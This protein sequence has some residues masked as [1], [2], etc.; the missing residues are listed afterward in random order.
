VV[1]A[2]HHLHR[3]LAIRFDNISPESVCAYFHADS[4][5]MCIAYVPYALHSVRI[6]FSAVFSIE[7]GKQGASIVRLHR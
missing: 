6:S 5:M 7:W 3:N 4:V 2:E 1:N